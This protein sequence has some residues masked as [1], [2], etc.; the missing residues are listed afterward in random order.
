MAQQPAR[1][2]RF[3]FLKKTEDLFTGVK[4]RVNHLISEAFHSP[5][6]WRSIFWDGNIA[7]EFPDRLMR[8]FRYLIGFTYVTHL[9]NLA[10]VGVFLLVDGLHSI[11]R[12]RFELSATRYWTDDVPRVARCL[13][14]V[15]IIGA[16]GLI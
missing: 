9:I 7:D 15:L 14:G 16:S 5:L 2:L 8:G 1:K 12:N 4:R 13:L 3:N 6:S 10:M 11:Y